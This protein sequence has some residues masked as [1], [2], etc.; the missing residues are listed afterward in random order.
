M[1]LFYNDFQFKN[2]YKE[3]LKKSSLNNYVETLGFGYFILLRVLTHKT[4]G[5]ASLSLKDKKICK[6][7]LRMI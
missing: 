3:L 1:L 2:Y 6:Y 4:A 5:A 7:Y